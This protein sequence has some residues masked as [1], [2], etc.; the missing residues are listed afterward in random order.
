MSSRIYPIW[1]NGK[2]IYFTD[3]S[4]LLEINQTLEAI[5]ETVSYIEKNNEYNLLE[6]LDI[7]GS[8]ASSQVLLALKNAGS[9]TKPYSLKKAMV[10]VTGSKRVLLIA[11][12]RFIDGSI[13]GFDNIEEAKEW[14]TADN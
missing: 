11:V 14:L 4:N 13:K 12:N 3:W 8:F 5:E 9:R 6:L 7:R 1:H 2:K 10:G